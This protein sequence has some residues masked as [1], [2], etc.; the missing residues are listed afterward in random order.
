MSPAGA[1]S[2]FL[3]SGY[4]LVFGITAIVCFLS[5]RQIRRIEPAEVRWGLGSLL[6]LSGF[7]AVSHI[8][9]LVSP[10]QQL[11]YAFYLVGLVV[12]F[13]TVGPWLYFCAAYTGRS[14]H[15]YRLVRLLALGVFGTVTAIKITNPVHHLYFT[16]EGA[17]T[18]FSYLLVHHQPLHWVVMGVAY[19]LAFVGFFLL[20]ELFVSIDYDTTPLFVVVS[21]AG[22]PV[23]LD[24]YAVTTPYLIELTYS[25]LGVAAFAIGVCYIYLERFQTV[26]LTSDV[27]EPVVVLNAENQVYEYNRSARKLFPE[28]TDGLDKPLAEIVPEIAES[29]TSSSPLFEYDRDGTTRYYRVTGRSLTTDQTQLSQVVSVTDV[30]EHEQYRQEL[31]RQNRRLEQFAGMIS[32]DLR[33]PLNV[34]ELQVTTAQ[35]ECDSEALEAAADALERMEELIEDVL[36]LARQGEPIDELERVE[37]STVVERSWKMVD[38]TG[39]D[40]QLT[41]SLVFQA[42]PDRVQQLLENLFRNAIEHAGPDVTVEVGTLEQPHTGFYVADDGPGIP[43]ADRKEVFESGYTT[44]RGGTGFGLAIVTEVVN[45]HG[46]TIDV[47]ESSAGGARFEIRFATV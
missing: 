28:L 18:P 5:L 35:Q 41:D 13:A 24:V 46:W 26:H 17:T 2:N 38:T 12:G 37:L 47:T 14:L 4:V 44:A 1:T 3:L 8:G 39:A 22:L 33:N 9:Y 21:F 23:I 42:D 11:Q 36:T 16:T 43:E 7:W 31:E 40:L 29:L 25:P 15:R 27:D 6:L 45:A 10:S 32:H 19:A 30:T 34:A 20:F